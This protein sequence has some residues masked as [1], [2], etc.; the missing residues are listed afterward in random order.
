MMSVNERFRIARRL[1]GLTQA[2]ASEQL[3]FSERTLS[4]WENRKVD[5][6]PIHWAIIIA[7]TERWL[8][9]AST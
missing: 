2:E 1:R 3:G 6:H 9:E 5:P 7:A 8:R 4:L